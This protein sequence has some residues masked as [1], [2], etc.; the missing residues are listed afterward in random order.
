MVR[1]IADQR[2]VL[3]GVLSGMALCA[4]PFAF[5]GFRKREQQV[6]EL[7]DGTWHA[8]VPDGWNSHEKTHKKC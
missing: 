4:V 5:D 8:H 6:A 3:L 2:K 7:R 1:V